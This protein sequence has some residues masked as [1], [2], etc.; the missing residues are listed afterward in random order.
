MAKNLNKAIFLN[1]GEIKRFSKKVKIDK[2]KIEIVPNGIDKDWFD[3][4]TEGSH[5]LTVGRIS[6]FK[7]QLEVSKAC[8]K[9]KIP[10]YMVGDA[11]DISYLEECIKHGAIYLG[12]KTKEEL[13][14]IYKDA[15]IVVLASRNEI[16][17]LSAME[18]IAQG[19]RVVM[20]S[21]SEW[22]PEG[23]E[24]CKYKSVGSIKKAILR[25]LEKPVNKFLRE[26]L[27]KNTWDKV[28]DK[29]IKIYEEAYRDNQL[30]RVSEPVQLLP[31]EDADKKL[32]GK[33]KNGGRRPK[34]DT[35]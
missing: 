2:D 19:K 13:K 33:A 4:Q 1:D 7:G 25:S 22:K 10:Y 8:E 29:L 27:K 26:E 9:I 15:R 17:S 23:I 18:A 16:M 20:T 28:A 30:H 12:K 21:G 32:Q 11:E 5:A 3:K 34:K 14:Q 35:K 24:Y 6:D 31:T